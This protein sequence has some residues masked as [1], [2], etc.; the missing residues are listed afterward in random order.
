MDNPSTYFCS[1]RN[2]IT[3]KIFISTLLSLRDLKFVASRSSNLLDF[4]IIQI[5]NQV[6]FEENGFFKIII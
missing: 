2:K 6:Y 5:L 3:L 1:F 4:I